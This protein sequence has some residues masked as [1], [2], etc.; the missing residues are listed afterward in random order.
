MKEGIELGPLSP[1]ECA[2]EEPP[3]ALEPTWIRIFSVMALISVMAY[4][5]VASSQAF[6]SFVPI[7]VASAVPSIW[8]VVTGLLAV[9]VTAEMAPFPRIALLV[10]VVLIPLAA[11]GISLLAVWTALGG[12]ALFSLFLRSAGSQA[13]GALGS[14]GL[15]TA[16]GMILGSAYGNR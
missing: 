3:R 16:V 2:E 15:L 4:L 5:L 14:V 9:N 10:L 8:A 13:L 7:P 1:V 12:T 11:Y 6:R